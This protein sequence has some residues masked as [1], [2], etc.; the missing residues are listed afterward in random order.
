MEIRVLLDFLHL[1][2]SSSEIEVILGL[3]LGNLDK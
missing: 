3:W 2:M 1:Y